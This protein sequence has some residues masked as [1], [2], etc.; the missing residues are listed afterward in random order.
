MVFRENIE[1][2]VDRNFQDEVS[3]DA[4]IAKLLKDFKMKE[5][6]NV[7]ASIDANAERHY[8]RNNWESYN[9]IFEK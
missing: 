5:Q 2:W 8:E 1:K 4:K 7:K 9:Y 3:N 6:S